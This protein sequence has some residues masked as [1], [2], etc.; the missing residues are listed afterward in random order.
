MQVI[1]SLGTFVSTIQELTTNRYEWLHSNGNYGVMVPQNQVIDTTG[2]PMQL[3]TS[4]PWVYTE[5]F[6]DFN[7]TAP[8]LVW[9]TNKANSTLNLSLNIVKFN[10]DGT[11]TETDQ[12]GNTFD[13]T[14][15]FLNN[16]TQVQVNNYHGTFTSTI[17]VLGT[18]RYEW[19]STNGSAYGEMIHP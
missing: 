19:L 17:K 6:I 7:L 16:Q 1:N 12:N 14:W 3:L 4:L 2:G 5:Y 13:G 8:S 18:D 9:K 11:Y 10:T 15:T